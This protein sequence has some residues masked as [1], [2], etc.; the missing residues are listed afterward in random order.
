[1]HK[2]IPEMRS[3]IFKEIP[4]SILPWASMWIICNLKVDN[5]SKLCLYQIIISYAYSIA[6]YN[7]LRMYCSIIM[8]FK[9]T[10]IGDGVQKQPIIAKI[11]KQRITPLGKCNF[12][13]SKKTIL[14][15]HPLNTCKCNRIIQHIVSTNSGDTIGYPI[16]FYLCLFFWWSKNDNFHFIIW[17]KKKK[18]ENIEF[19]L[20]Y[21]IPIYRN[22]YSSKKCWTFVDNH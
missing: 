11:L 22:L 9:I 4:L 3:L 17:M 10:G 2:L 1:M 12:L 18:R 8:K 21:L 13:A 15:V 16:Y 7:N 6:S 20:W 19:Y 14:S 5:I